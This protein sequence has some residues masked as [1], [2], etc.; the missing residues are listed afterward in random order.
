MS[1]LSVI[2]AIFPHG[3]AD[4]VAVCATKE[5]AISAWKAYM[6]NGEERQSDKDEAWLEA[7]GE[8]LATV[9]KT[10]RQDSGVFYRLNPI[11]QR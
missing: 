1:K 6:R 4:T 10:E 9:G 8:Y 5:G 7:N 3:D 2:I 11:I